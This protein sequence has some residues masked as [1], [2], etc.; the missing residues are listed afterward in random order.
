MS[1]FGVYPLG[2]SDEQEERARR[3]HSESIIIDMLYW[4]PTS[5]RAYTPAMEAE[6]RA[7]YAAHQSALAN[8]MDSL[9]Q[10]A[11]WAMAG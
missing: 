3:L 11:R 1:E 5:H 10:P 4:G 2:L 7:K 9:H 8:V 6:L